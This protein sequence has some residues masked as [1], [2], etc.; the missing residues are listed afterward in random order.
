[1]SDELI[2]FLLEA[3]VKK[4]VPWAWSNS[5]DLF[6]GEPL[7]PVYQ[8]NRR[9]IPGHRW[10]RKQPDLNPESCRRSDECLPRF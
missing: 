10:N 2:K 7:P 1:M 4:A 8:F 5:K 3:A 6:T 9:E